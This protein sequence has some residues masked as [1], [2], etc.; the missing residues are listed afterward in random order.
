M[1]LSI[2]WESLTRHQHDA[3]FT[4][5][6]DLHAD[7]IGRVKAEEGHDNTLLLAFATELTRAMHA[8]NDDLV[9]REHRFER[10][11]CDC[12]VCP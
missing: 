8:A 2:E 10:Q 4:A 7:V 12:G 11:P 9:R 6:K 1:V 5:L 3:M